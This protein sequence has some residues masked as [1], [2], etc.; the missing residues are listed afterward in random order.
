MFDKSDSQGNDEKIDSLIDEFKEFKNKRKIVELDLEKKMLSLESVFD[1][2][3]KNI[4]IIQGLEDADSLKDFKNTQETLRSLEDLT[5][6]DRLDIMQNKETIHDF[7]EKIAVFNKKI[8]LMS[9]ALKIFD[10]KMKNSGV[11]QSGTANDSDLVTILDELSKIKDTISGLEK[12]KPI[13]ETE[14]NKIH[15]DFEKVNTDFATLISGV[16]EELGTYDKKIEMLVNE[17]ENIKSIDTDIGTNENS[18]LGMLN[19]IKKMQAMTNILTEKSNK[20]EISIHELEK[21]TGIKINT[22]A[23]N[24][25]ML[26]KIVEKTKNNPGSGYITGPEN[27]EKGAIANIEFKIAELD[28]VISNMTGQIEEEKTYTN[29]KIS[30]AMDAIK[31]MLARK[32][33]TADLT[34]ID[35]CQVREEIDTI[36]DDY[37]RKLDSEIKNISLANE[38][39]KNKVEGISEQ[40]ALIKNIP[41]KGQTEISQGH[42]DRKISNMEEI[43]AMQTKINRIL[44]DKIDDIE[45]NIYV[46]GKAVSGTKDNIDT[47]REQFNNSISEKLGNLTMLDISAK[48]KERDSKIKKIEQKNNASLKAVQSKVYSILSGIQK[49]ISLLR[50]FTGTRTSRIEDE[51]K[52]IKKFN[53]NMASTVENMADVIKKDGE[54]EKI[55]VLGKINSLNESLSAIED[56]ILEDRTD[57]KNRHKDIEGKICT[58]E[59]K[60]NKLVDNI[61]KSLSTINNLKEMINILECSTKERIE[62]I[63]NENIKNADDAKRSMDA[64]RGNIS[65][66]IR[67]IEHEHKRSIEM[68]ENDIEKSRK[69]IEADLKV[70][71]NSN[72]ELTSDINKITE[73]NKKSFKEESERNEKKFE[74]NKNYIDESIKNIADKTE[75]IEERITE[76]SIKEIESIE[77]ILKLEKINT[78]KNMKLIKDDT[79]SKVVLIEEKMIEHR[80]E[81]NDNLERI[82]N[83]GKEIVGVVKKIDEALETS[84]AKTFIKKLEELEKTREALKAESLNDFLI[85]F[86]EMKILKDSITEDFK[87]LKGTVLSLQSKV[88]GGLEKKVETDL[89]DTL[90]NVKTISDTFTE[91]I[92]GSE[93]RND[94]KISSLEEKLAYSLSKMEETETQLKDDI[95]NFRKMQREQIDSTKNILEKGLD[96]KLKIFADEQ[97]RKINYITNEEIK[98]IVERQDRNLSEM[99]AELNASINIAKGGFHESHKEGSGTDIGYIAGDTRTLTDIQTQINKAMKEKISNI[100]KKISESGALPITDNTKNIVEMIT[101]LKQENN[102]LS[103]DIKEL[104]EQLS[105]IGHT[106][107]AEGLP[108][109]LE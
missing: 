104:K 106:G 68:L 67:S 28:N 56:T 107:R 1:K 95:S 46:L 93:K 63:E 13:G 61:L 99:K 54:E 30:N 23:K 43:S 5:L 40:I 12:K 7:A 62:K 73:L 89:S 88:D 78:E 57:T 11:N 101:L 15:N 94:E 96:E 92:E 84:T 2:I 6:T 16:R 39:I 49:E 47:N 74:G 70:L 83:I 20:S 55:K 29:Q 26:I 51:F 45:K 64:E 27:I 42:S 36:K 75:A 21:D 86:G 35:T 44:K 60:N 108:L 34:D 77:D 81:M 3:K 52:S 31:D 76:K 53:E 24:M 59:G 18:Y 66:N 8:D 19:L 10:E 98:E 9:N 65:L 22:L 82:N 90:T 87:N 58:I 4:E 97:K 41:G 37:K 33:N 102:M 25:E 50:E 85:R 100:E 14:F 71:K 80:K 91:N 48:L 105:S 17:I 69:D 79:D 72:I 103:K 38:E 32:G 109:I